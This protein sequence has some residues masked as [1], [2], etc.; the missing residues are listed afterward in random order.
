MLQESKTIDTLSGL[1]T[2]ELR[3]GI[4]SRGEPVHIVAS[5]IGTGHYK[6]YH[7]E[8]FTDMREAIN[9]FDSYM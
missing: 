1:R 6:M 4:S 8:R 7:E 3:E 2:V 5:Y 9:W